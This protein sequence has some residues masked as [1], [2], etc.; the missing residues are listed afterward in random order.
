MSDFANTSNWEKLT[1]SSIRYRNEHHGEG[2]LEKLPRSVGV[3]VNRISVMNTTAWTVADKEGSDSTTG[4]TS[5]E[6][7]KVDCKLDRARV[8]VFTLDET[9]T[10]T[11]DQ[12]EVDIYPISIETLQAASKYKR[13]STV[14][15]QYRPEDGWLKDE[16]GRITFHEAGDYFEKPLLSA[17]LWLDQATFDTTV[18]QIKHGETIARAGLEILA[19]FFQFGY[20][21]WIAGPRTTSNYG[22]L[23]ESDGRRTKGYTTAR[24]EELW[25]E[26]S[27]K[28]D[29]PK[30]EDAPFADRHS[31]H[32]NNGQGVR[33]ASAVA[34]DL[35]QIRTRV[36]NFYQVMIGLAVVWAALEVLDRLGG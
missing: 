34:R 23:S 10:T 15:V 29:R 14:G 30:D 2:E 36:D 31:D 18:K 21:G 25:L 28:L 20:E 26:W 9:P 16:H 22:I 6:F 3:Q 19:D 12:M 1:N 5:R 24:L 7:I 8:H 27:P 35:S 33:A 17:V 11:F 13:W 32:T 4:F